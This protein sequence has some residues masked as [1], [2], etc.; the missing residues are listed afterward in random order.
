MHSQTYSRR[1]AVASNF[2]QQLL[3]QQSVHL[4]KLGWYLILHW[5]GSARLKVASQLRQF[6]ST[7]AQGTLARTKAGVD[8]QEDCTCGVTREISALSSSARS[9]LPPGYHELCMPVSDIPLYR[10]FA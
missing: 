4:L 2:A 1:V 7:V 5:G 9:A 6:E 8:K 10:S 3:G